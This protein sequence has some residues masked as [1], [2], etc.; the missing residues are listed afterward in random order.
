MLWRTLL[1]DPHVTSQKPR[2]WE[3]QGLIIA[4]TYQQ[5][6]SQVPTVKSLQHHSPK[7]SLT[8]LTLAPGELNQFFP[9]LEKSLLSQRAAFL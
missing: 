9:A 3:D 8:G 1:E 4:F 5:V 7:L 2:N 6:R